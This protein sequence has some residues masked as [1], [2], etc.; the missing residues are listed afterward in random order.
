MMSI[1]QPRNITR[2]GLYADL[3]VLATGELGWAIDTR[4]LFMGNNSTDDP[5]AQSSGNVEILTSLSNTGPGSSAGVTTFN[6]RAGDVL[7]G[8]PDISNAL[9]YT[10]DNPINVG[11]SGGTIQS[12][13]ITGGNIITAFIDTPTI[14]NA[15]ISYSSIIPRVSYISTVNDI[16]TP[17]CDIADINITIFPVPTII[18]APAYIIPP[19]DG[20]QLIL[21][22]TNYSTIVWDPIYQAIGVT[23]PT[24]TVSGAII[25][26]TMLC[27]NTNVNNVSTIRWDVISMAVST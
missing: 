23:L 7:L 18:A 8:S 17:Q 3:L 10:P 24:S 4:R 14:V 13:D 5:H 22:I 20:Q 11:I 19:A 2:H 6:T 1:Q 26:A 25:Y 12:T 9:G 16:F 21:R 27:I 15:K